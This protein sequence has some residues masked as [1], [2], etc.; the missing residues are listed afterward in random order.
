MLASNMGTLTR[1]YL[2]ARAGGAGTVSTLLYRR[3]CI[4]KYQLEVS[5]QPQDEHEQSGPMMLVIRV[6][7]VKL[8]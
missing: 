8:L 2:A 1:P 6:E 3:K 4:K 7:N 5:L